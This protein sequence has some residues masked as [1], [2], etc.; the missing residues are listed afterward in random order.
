MKMV[1]K[2]IIKSLLQQNESTKVGSG[3]VVL[4]EHVIIIITTQTLLIQIPKSG[5]LAAEL[6]APAT[7]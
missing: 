5:Q 3:S 6:A 7:C 1:Y 4:T 2:L